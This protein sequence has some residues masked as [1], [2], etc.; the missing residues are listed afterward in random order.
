[1]PNKN[2]S[3]NIFD[4]LLDTPPISKL[5]KTT[6]ISDTEKAISKSLSDLYGF[7]VK[8]SIEGCDIPNER[9]FGSVALRGLTI[10]N[11]IS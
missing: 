2:D 11:D 8:V 6:P 4:R 9:G 5:F 3:D 7:P 10:E 1:M